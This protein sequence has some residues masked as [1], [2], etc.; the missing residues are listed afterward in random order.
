MEVGTYAEH[1]C[2]IVSRSVLLTKVELAVGLLTVDDV[3]PV[4]DAG[5]HVGDLEV[6]PLVVVVG[7]DIRTQDQIV[8]MLSDLEINNHNIKNRYFF[9]KTSHF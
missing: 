5:L 9:G 6:E 4:L 1:Y 2:V 8:L 3:E 7:V